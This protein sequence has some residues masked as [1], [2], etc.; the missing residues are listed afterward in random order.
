MKAVVHHTLLRSTGGATRVA[1]LLAAHISGKS[2][3]TW[4]LDESEPA[5]LVPLSSDDIAGTWADVLQRGGLLHLHSAR[6]WPSTLELAAGLREKYPGGRVVLTLHDCSVFTGGC[7]YP[8]GCEKLALGCPDPCPRAFVRSAERR[9]GLLHLLQRCGAE[10][11]SPSSW[12]KTVARPH[13]PNCSIKVIPNGVPW[14]DKVPD[15]AEARRHIGVVRDVRMALFVAH[16]GEKAVYKGG[17]YWA[18]ICGRIRENVPGMLFVL[19][20]GGEHKVEGDTVYWPYL[21][22]ERL[23]LLMRAADVLV[24]PT[25]ADNHS[26]IVL[27]AM[28]AHCP[29]V[30]WSAGGLPEQ[31]MH[32]ETGLLAPER[33]QETLVRHCIELLTHPTLVRRL[34]HEA[35]TEGRKRFGVQRMVAGYSKVYGRGGGNNVP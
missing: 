32:G 17:Q 27:E 24:Y 7:V 14:P 35:F 5:A 3:H 12:L 13:C 1:Q 34:G 28:A 11:V 19:A 20:G 21:D 18:D 23:A 4:E 8:L 26:L 2:L 30:A 10:L 9:A 15:K 33:D 22:P 6:D 29:V 31:V 16:G 25:L